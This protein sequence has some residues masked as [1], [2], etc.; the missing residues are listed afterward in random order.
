MTTA[1]HAH[2][3]PDKVDDDEYDDADYDDG[4]YDADCWDRVAVVGRIV[5]LSENL[6]T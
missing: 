4:D 2:M 3:H 6:T 1:H 5:G